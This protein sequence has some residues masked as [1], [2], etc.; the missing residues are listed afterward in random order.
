MV[1]S[2]LSR[3]PVMAADTELKV[4]SAVCLQLYLCMNVSTCSV[5]VLCIYV[6]VCVCVCCSLAFF[7]AIEHVLT[8]KSAIEIKSLLL[9]LLLLCAHC[10]CMRVCILHMCLP[11]VCGMWKGNFLGTDELR[12]LMN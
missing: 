5:H 4:Y 1:G 11:P 7:S 3:D 8:W 6:C 12:E 9:L 2:G 10:L